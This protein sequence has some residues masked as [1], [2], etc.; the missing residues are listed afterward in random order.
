MHSYF[1]LHATIICLI[2]DGLICTRIGVQLWVIFELTQCDLKTKTR[3]E[4]LN[5]TSLEAWMKGSKA[6]ALEHTLRLFHR[7][8]E[9]GL[10]IFLI[11]SRRETLRSSTVDNLIQVGYHGWSGLTLRYIMCIYYI[12]IFPF[13]ISG[14]RIK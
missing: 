7:I 3:G 11:S 10:K 13:L 1:Q 12:L 5:S 6:P 8:K 4:K 14:I 2:Y 9:K